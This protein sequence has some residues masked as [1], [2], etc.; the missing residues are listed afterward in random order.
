MPV[1]SDMYDWESV[2]QIGARD[3]NTIGMC[4]VCLKTLTLCCK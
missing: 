1:I 2:R 3:E 4:V